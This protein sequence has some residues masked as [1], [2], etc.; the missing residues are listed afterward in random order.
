M[1]LYT[2][3]ARPPYD[4]M[5][6]LLSIDLFR[7]LSQQDLDEVA[8]R[9]S[10]HSYAQGVMLFH[11]DMPGTMLYMIEE[12]NV[13]VFGVGL[14]GQ[15]HT[16]NTFGPGRSVWRTIDFGWQTAVRIRRNHDA[17]YH[18]MLSKEDLDT[19]LERCFTLSRALIVL[20]SERVRTAAGHVEAIIF[21]DV[22]GRLAY[23]LLNFVERHGKPA[24]NG[25][26]IDIPLTQSNLATV[27]GATRESVNKALGYLRKNH[28]V[29]VDGTQITVLD[30]DGLRQFIHDRGR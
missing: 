16:F 28:L 29:Q 2:R 13:R 7:D 12:G 1:S 30:V 10:R 26:Q 6:F 22:P 8:R 24:M 27:V 25:I 3:V 23:E 5:T 15:E 21:Q 4:P 9:I 14:T 19:L 11:Q 20:L 18:W 17:L